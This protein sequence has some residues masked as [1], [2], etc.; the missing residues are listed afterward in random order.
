MLRAYIL[1]SLEPEE[2]IFWIRSWP[3][4]VLSSPRVLVRSSLF[5][6]HKLPALILLVDC[7]IVSGDDLLRCLVVSGSQVRRLTGGWVGGLGLFKV[8]SCVHALFRRGAADSQSQPPAFR[9]NR[10][11]NRDRNRDAPFWRGFDVSRLSTGSKNRGLV[12]R[13]LLSYRERS[14]EV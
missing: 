8:R 11:F 12:V 2:A 4:S 1:F 7:D 10:N 6:D 3:S 5:F 9:A 13:G 14:I